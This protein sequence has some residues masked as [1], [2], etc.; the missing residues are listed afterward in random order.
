MSTPPPDLHDPSAMNGL[1]PLRVYHT[2]SFGVRGTA[3]P[4]F[5]TLS[6]E[7]RWAVAFYTMAIRQPACTRR[8]PRLSLSE[9]ARANDNHLVARFGEPSL[10]CLRR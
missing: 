1:S 3:M 10:P 7:D 4:E 6:D 5:P 8:G 2:V 9:R